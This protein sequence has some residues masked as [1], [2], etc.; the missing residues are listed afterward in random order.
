MQD[1]D[2]EGSLNRTS[3]FEGEIAHNNDINLTDNNN[4]MELI[5]ILKPNFVQ[6]VLEPSNPVNLLF[7]D[8]TDVFFRGQYNKNTHHRRNSSKNDSPFIG[9]R[10]RCSSNYT[11]ERSNGDMYFEG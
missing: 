4:H 5:N 3:G 11:Q 7:D 8:E 6:S 2:N 9:A 10:Q 1:R